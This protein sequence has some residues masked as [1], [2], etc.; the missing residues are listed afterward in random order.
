[1]NFSLIFKEIRKTEMLTQF[2]FASKLN[3]SRSTVAQIEISNN[4]PS[5]KLIFRLLDV[6]DVPEDFKKELEMYTKRTKPIINEDNENGDLSSSD[7]NNENTEDLLWKTYGELVKNK[8]NLLCLCI[9]LKKLHCYEFSREEQEKFYSIEIAIEYLHNFVFATIRYNETRYKKARA[10]LKLSI[11][12]IEE[13]STRIL[14]YY[15][16]SVQVFQD[17]TVPKE[18]NI[19]DN[20]VDL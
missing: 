5:R 10:A 1:M 16:S 13:Y 20:D 2:D 18:Y 4:K 8:K 6:F 14:P 12:L 7:N 9:L 15:S 11:E 19:N 17:L 3:I